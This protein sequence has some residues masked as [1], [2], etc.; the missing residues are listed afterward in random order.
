MESQL[1]SP[2]IIEDQKRRNQTV[3]VAPLKVLDL[4]NDVWD[5]YLKVRD[6]LLSDVIVMHMYPQSRPK[7]KQWRTKPFPLYDEMAD[8]VDGSRASGKRKY[9]PK[10]KREEETPG[11][12]SIPIDPVLLA[13]SISQGKLYSDIDSDSDV[14]SPS[15]ALFHYPCISRAILPRTHTKIRPT[16]TTNPKGEIR[17]L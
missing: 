15:L 11:P 8:L 16:Q 17:A 12:S 3:Q 7:L 6:V 1:A 2:S 13:E 14:R 4:N 5:K 10:K 9:K